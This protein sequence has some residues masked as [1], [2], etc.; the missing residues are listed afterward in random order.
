LAGER[1]AECEGFVAATAD[2]VTVATHQEREQLHRLYGIHNA[3]IEVIP[4]GVDLR[5]FTPGTPAQRRAARTMLGL[6]Q[7]P[8]VLAVGRLDPIKGTDLL[9][10]A[11]ALMR[12]PVTLIL[13]GG[14]PAGDPELERLRERAFNLGIGGRV[15]LPGAVAHE[16][17]APYYRAADALVVAS[18]YE[19]FGLVAVE[20]MAC[21]TPVVAAKVGGLPSIVCDD[22][23][24]VLVPLRTPRAF[25]EQLDSL[26][27]DRA[28]LRRLGAA[29][30]PTVERFDW[31]RVGDHVRS[32][33]QDLR[34]ACCCAEACSCF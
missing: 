27:G 6:G 31:H 13:V 22:E 12:T 15:K 7:G 32:V 17:L 4:C 1:R 11:L 18:R 9:L 19:S 21:G 24:G 28:R 14:D 25:A 2:R 10:E 8:V 23:N 30:R 29:A 5:T 20:A 26:L 33:Y 3:R 16:M 34:L